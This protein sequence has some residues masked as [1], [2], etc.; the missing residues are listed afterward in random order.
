[1]KISNKANGMKSIFKTPIIAFIAIVVAFSL[2]CGPMAEP[3]TPFRGVSLII[4][5]EKLVSSPSTFYVLDAE[6]GLPD[7][8]FNNIT[9]T[10]KDA[11]CVVYNSAGKV[12]LKI[13]NGVIQTAFS[14]VPLAGRNTNPNYVDVNN[15]T[16]AN[17][18]KYNLVIKVPGYNDMMYPVIATNPYPT[19]HEIYLSKQNATFFEKFENYQRGLSNTNGIILSSPSVGSSFGLNLG[20]KITDKNGNPMSGIVDCKWKSLMLGSIPEDRPL[21]AFGNLGENTIVDTNGNKLKESF[22]YPLMVHELNVLA[23][24]KEVYNILPEDVNDKINFGGTTQLVSINPLTG[25]YFNS[26]TEISILSQR[27]GESNWVLEETFNVKF[28]GDDVLAGTFITHPGKWVW[29]IISKPVYVDVGIPSPRFDN[30]FSTLNGTIDYYKP[31]GTTVLFSEKIRSTSLSN[32]FSVRLP[33]KSF[34][35][36]KLREVFLS[37]NHKEN[38]QLKQELFFNNPM[39]ASSIPTNNSSINIYINSSDIYIFP[40]EV[41]ELTSGRFRGACSGGGSK[42]VVLPLF[43]PIYYIEESKADAT[44]LY[45]WKSFEASVDVDAQW[46]FGAIIGNGYVAGT[47]YRFMTIYNNEIFKK[48]VSFKFD[49]GNAIPDIEFLNLPCSQ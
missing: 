6:T 21:K 14:K 33:V 32:T 23:D 43:Y 47:K 29:A 44:P 49:G 8:A 26:G 19:V 42:Y 25:T 13:I 16:E 2:G 5:A 17:P 28:N 30:L 45:Q 38:G 9:V 37:V 10:V 22:I 48:I 34:M 12:E 1:M 7:P 11:N 31:D 39:S 27:F 35:P 3:P 41:H 36:M 20:E 15:I 40:R 46:N 18:Y 4:S 24:G